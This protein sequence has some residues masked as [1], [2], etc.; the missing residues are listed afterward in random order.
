M[1]K[2]ESLLGSSD[3]FIEPSPHPEVLRH[4]VLWAASPSCPSA[5]KKPQD[6]RPHP[7]CWL[8]H[9]CGLSAAPA[10]SQ[11]TAP[12]DHKPPRLGWDTQGTAGRTQWAAEGPGLACGRPRQAHITASMCRIRRASEIWVLVS[13]WPYMPTRKARCSSTAACSAGK[14]DAQAG[15]RLPRAQ[16]GGRGGRAAHPGRGGCTPAGS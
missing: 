14:T 6:R 1:K 16:A 7:S 5:G 12:L 15:G 10:L 4:P 3:G 8:K 13:T 9:P 11:W 2:P